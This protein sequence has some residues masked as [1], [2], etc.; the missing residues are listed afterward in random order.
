MAAIYYSTSPTVFR[1]LRDQYVRAGFHVT[2]VELPGHTIGVAT[3]DGRLDAHVW[4][5]NQGGVV[6]SAKIAYRRRTGRAALEALHED[7]GRADTEGVVGGGLLVFATT[8][9]LRVVSDSTASAKLYYS[10]GPDGVSFSSEL[11]YLARALPQVTLDELALLERTFQASILGDET[12]F[13]ECACLS[14]GDELHVAG[15]PA[16]PILTRW[17]AP[18]LSPT[19]I[20]DPAGHIAERAQEIYAELARL[21]DRFTVW[22]TG[23]LDSRLQLALMLG[24]GIDRERIELVYGV[25]N[26]FVTNTRDRD[27]EI[28]Q[29]IADGEGLRLEQLDWTDG[30][31]RF[32]DWDHALDSFGQH[33]LQYGC[34]IKILGQYVERLRRGSFAT[35]GYFGELL[36][37]LDWQRSAR[38]PGTLTRL[39]HQYLKVNPAQLGSA[40]LADRMVEKLGRFVTD[41]STVRDED[42]V[43]VYIAYRR[44]ADTKQQELCAM[45]GSS[46][47][48]LGDPAILQLI[49]GV[50]FKQKARS[51]TLTRIM[52]ASAPKLLS[53]PV[54][55][56]Q[57]DVHLRPNGELRP[58][59]FELVRSA[60]RRQA[61]QLLAAV[62]SIDRLVREGLGQS[63]GSAT[64]PRELANK[65]QQQVGVDLIDTSSFQSDPRLM[66]SFAQ[67]LHMFG[68]CEANAPPPVHTTDS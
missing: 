16:K 13:Q 40:E 21:C 36:R 58:T 3:V 30:D 29:Q 37:P 35:F 22:M 45:F 55:S 34:N 48:V 12:I 1:A 9:S 32:V 59:R 15:G 27:L 7:N 10:S 19:I 68:R 18:A 60:S 4:L 66:L 2:N 26:S 50:P 23:G 53:Y 24:A 14:A 61:A 43:R 64:W 42:V 28:V 65:V 20:D 67:Y 44:S 57:R 62:P 33:G 31:R 25:G 11:Y 47:P 49:L 39:A 8:G 6:S 46:F 51:R 63:N 17:R 38:D 41:P 54:F 52:E 5:G 56:H